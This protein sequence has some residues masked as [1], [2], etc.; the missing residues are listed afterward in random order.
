MRV[1]AIR[2]NVRCH[3][4]R[5]EEDSGACEGW[6]ADIGYASA[7]DALFQE[8]SKW[9]DF[10]T[11]F[12]AGEVHGDINIHRPGLRR[13]R[14]VLVV[15]LVLGVLSLPVPPQRP[16]SAPSEVSAP[17]ISVQESLVN[18][19]AGKLVDDEPSRGGAPNGY[20]AGL[21]YEI[22]VQTQRR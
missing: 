7:S 6:I 22:V 15:G 12:Q 18:E 2:F 21:V 17:K 20:I 11:L 8:F 1:P 10:G 14:L 3:G 13:F 9:S 19:C 5:S 16:A 4:I